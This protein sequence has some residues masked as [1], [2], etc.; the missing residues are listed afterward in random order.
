MPSRYSISTATVIMLVLL[1]L[2]I[3]WHFFSEGMKHYADPH[4]TSEAT[5]RSATGPLAPM[6]H[7]YLPDFHGFEIL[8]H[9]PAGD[10]ESEAVS[11][12]NNEIQTDWSNELKQF[13][14]HFALDEDQQAKAAKVFETYKV[15]LQDWFAANQEALVQHVHQWHRKEAT[16]DLPS[17]GVPY[18][19]KRLAANQSTLAGEARGWLADLK[20]LEGDYD[21]ALRALVNPAQRS[22]YPMARSS[23]SIDLVDGVMTY[24]ILGIGLLLLLGLFTRL[25]CLAGAAFLLSVVMMQ[26][27]WVSDALPTYNQYVEMFALLALAT[28][29]V[30]RWGGLDFF[31]HSL[32]A[33]SSSATKGQTD[34]SYS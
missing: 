23:N 12:W 5:L 6:Y 25:A 33:G 7:A 2:N 22:Q 19:K 10:N 13:T 8:L 30:G 28:T 15:R 27:F 26:P 3:G 21:T 17:A 11:R 29:A 32:F 1:R 9:G 34:V 20:E 31:L 16:A 14:G 24:A 4:W 18:Q